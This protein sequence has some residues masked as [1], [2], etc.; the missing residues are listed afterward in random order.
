MKKQDLDSII[1]INANNNKF[2]KIATIMKQKGKDSSRLVLTSG[3]EEICFNG[4]HDY[5]SDKVNIVNGIE[6][7]EYYFLNDKF[8]TEEHLYHDINVDLS[9]ISGESIDKLKELC[10]KSKPIDVEY[11]FDYDNY[12]ITKDALIYQEPNIIYFNP[13]YYEQPYRVTFKLK[14][15]SVVIE[16]HKAELYFVERV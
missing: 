7:D 6:I 4:L 16:S 12:F 11:C 15:K 8:K 5:M 2:R 13:M 14:C 9:N 1:N 3:T 10:R